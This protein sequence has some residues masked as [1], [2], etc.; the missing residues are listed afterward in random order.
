[1]WSL[2]VFWQVMKDPGSRSQHGNRKHRHDK[3]T[4]LKKNKPCLNKSEGKN[5]D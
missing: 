2:A 1:M 4:L 3:E 5:W